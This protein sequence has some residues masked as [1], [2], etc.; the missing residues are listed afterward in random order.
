MA[1]HA[2]R[3]GAEGPAF[4]HQPDH[5]DLRLE[6]FGLLR[7]GPPGRRAAGPG[8]GLLLH[9]C[10]GR[11]RDLGHRSSARPG[12]RHQAGIGPR[13]E[14]QPRDP[15]AV[16]PP[17]HRRGAPD[18]AGPDRAGGQ[19]GGK[20]QRRLRPGRHRRPDR[21]GGRDQLRQPD[22]RAGVPPRRGGRRAQDARRPAQGPD[23]PV[24]RRG[25]DPGRPGRPGRGGPGRAAGQTLQRLRPAG[26]GGRL[27]PRPRAARSATPCCS[28]A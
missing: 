28:R 18:G 11:P 23:D 17:A 27:P 21:A 16:P 1:C 10:A 9:L 24:H 2:G 13:L 6:P 22:D 8:R 14:V 3:R 20:P 26:A 7:P 25:P 4:Q 5:R 12:Y 15:V 19:A